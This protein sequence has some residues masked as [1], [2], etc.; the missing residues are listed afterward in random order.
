MG[1]VQLSEYERRI[2]AEYEAE[3]AEDAKFTK[4]MSRTSAGHE[5]RRM[6]MWLGIALVVLVS[7]GVL[8]S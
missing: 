4:Q 1:E 3:F 7:Y 2:L 5:L 8:V 6:L